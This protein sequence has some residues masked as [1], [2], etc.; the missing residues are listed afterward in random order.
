MKGVRLE[1]IMYS[2]LDRPKP[3]RS[4]TEELLGAEMSKAGI[5]FGADTQYGENNNRQC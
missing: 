1:E 3:Y 4:A 5:A 2:R